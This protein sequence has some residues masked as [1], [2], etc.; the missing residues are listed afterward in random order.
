MNIPFLLLSAFLSAVPIIFWLMVLARKHRSNMVFF[1]GLNFVMAMGFSALFQYKLENILSFWIQGDQPN[2]IMI[3]LSFMAM[4]VIIEYGKNFIVRLTGGKYFHT[5]D[6]V[7]DLSFA[8]AL[9]F[10]FYRNTF[11]FYLLFSGGFPEIV[12]PV[13]I[14][15]DMLENI[16]FILPVHLFCSGIF[17]YFYGLSLFAKE[18]LKED[19]R[20]RF[21]RYKVF[22]FKT[23]KIM[24]GSFISVVFYGIF[25]S[26]LKFDPTFGDVIQWLGMDRNILFGIDEKLMPLISFFYFS[27][28]TLFLFQLMDQKRD[29]SRKKLLVDNSKSKK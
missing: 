14:F 25:F 27:V 7:M 21:K 15:K 23:M 29:F 26:V 8:T 17:G 2:G 3:F 18:E 1:F 16:F 20:N 19:H 9:G 5:I 11:H 6:D 13:K 4:G 22:A 28:G 24:E 12:G 10:M